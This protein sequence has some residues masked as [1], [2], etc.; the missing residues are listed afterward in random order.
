M[1][2]KAV[3]LIVLLV[4]LVI[5][6]IQNT[7]AVNVRFLFWGFSTSAVLT[8]LMSFVIGFLVGWLT[9]RFRTGDKTPSGASPAVAPTKKEG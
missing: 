2:V 8:I 7:Q 9:G 3:G 5:F 1:N 6:S 4:L